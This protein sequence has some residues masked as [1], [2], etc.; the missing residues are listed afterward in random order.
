MGLPTE[1]NTAAA[2]AAPVTG[3]HTCLKPECLVDAWWAVVC[4]AQDLGI[5]ATLNVEDP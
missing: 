2:S 3:M 5:A 1:T 4:E